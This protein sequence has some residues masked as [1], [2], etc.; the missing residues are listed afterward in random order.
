M[1]TNITQYKQWESQADQG[2]L[3][4]S[5]REKERER[6][7]GPRKLKLFS[8]KDEASV[9][10]LETTP[11]YHGETIRGDKSKR[12]ISWFKNCYCPRVVDSVGMKTDVRCPVQLSFPVFFS[13]TS[14]QAGEVL[15]YRSSIQINSLQSTWYSL[16][17]SQ[18]NCLI[19]GRIRNSLGGFVFICCS[20]YS[21]PHKLVN[22]T[23]HVWF[24]MSGKC[25]GMKLVN[26]DRKCEE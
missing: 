25:M 19:P 11:E 14:C 6:A 7:N 10:I 3:P 21:E 26:I 13:E 5:E 9:L 17:K 20:C 12:E 22:F 15:S 1:I 18:L 4:S 24:K 16:Y 23:E 2:T 8:E